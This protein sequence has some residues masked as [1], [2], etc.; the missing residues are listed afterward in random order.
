MNGIRL[1]TIITQREYEQAYERFLQEHGMTAIFSTP[2]QGTATGSLLDL[3]G[4]AKTGKSLMITMAERELAGRAMRGM[5]SQMGI[6]MPGNGI[7]LTIPVSSIGGVSCMKYLMEKQSMIIGEVNCVDDKSS[8]F[9]YELLVAITERGRV[10]M[11]MDAAKTAGARGG[12]IIHAKGTGTEFTA[13]FFGISIA[14]E[15]DVALIVVNREDKCGIMRAIMEH[16]G[17]RSEA[18]TA[19][20]SLPVEDVVGLTS[21]MHDVEGE[22]H[23]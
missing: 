14:S 1:L 22:E 16:A 3:L 23:V 19:L 18:H 9:S 10:D 12:T 15:K 5:V 7:A 17:M 13:K 2:C 4:L 20:I 11:V 8:T 21:V 6:N